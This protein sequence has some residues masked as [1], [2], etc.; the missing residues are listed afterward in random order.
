ML[1]QEMMEK[2]K[3]HAEEIRELHE[4]MTK[5]ERDRAASFQRNQERL[6]IQE[7]EF[8]QKKNLEIEQK[9]KEQ[10]EQLKKK[11]DDDLK[12]IKQQIEE[13][14]I[15]MNFPNP[16]DGSSQNDRGSTFNKSHNINFDLLGFNEDQ[17]KQSSK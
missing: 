14:N 13:Q 5:M 2:E 11:H 1:Q 4:K 7:L 3:K 12:V 6:S 10:S 15:F 16:L 8:E 17:L 9:L